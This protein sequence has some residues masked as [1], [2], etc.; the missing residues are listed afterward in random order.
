MRNQSEGE[1]VWRYS[2][3]DRA[4][5]ASILKLGHMWFLDTVVRMRG[6]YVTMRDHFSCSYKKKSYPNPPRSSSLLTVDP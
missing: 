1:C 6:K 3:L 2:V 4:P 5:H